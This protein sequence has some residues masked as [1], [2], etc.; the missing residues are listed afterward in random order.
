MQVVHARCCGLDVHKKTVVACTLLTSSDGSVEKHTRTFSPMT[1]D[2]LALADWLDTL[3]VS[4]VAMESTGVFWRPV[5]NLLEEGRSVM[6]VNAQHMRAVPGHKTDVKDS[7][8]L[9]DLLRHG[10][11]KASF[12]PPQPIRQLRELTRY[13]K[14]LVQERAQEVNRLQKVLE[15]ANVKL[16]AVATDILGKSG[17]SI[18]AALL[19][20]ERDQQVLAELARGRMRSKRA[21]LQDALTGRLQP[22]H[23]VL[24]ERMLEHVDF[25][26]ASLAQLQQAI[27][28]C[29]A[30]FEE[31][32]ELVQTI[33][34]VQAKAASTIVAEIG[35]DMTRFP[36]AKHLASWAGV[37][38]GN[39]ESGGKRLSGKTTNGNTYL[40]AVLT[41]V[42]WVVSRM[43]DNYLA[44]QYH[45]LARRL[46]K[47]KAAVAV[48][49]SI[50]V[51]VYHILRTHKP[52]TELG[53]HY[54]DQLDA[55]RVQQH[56]VHR[57]EQLGYTVTLSP[58]GPVDSVQL[59][60]GFS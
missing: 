43:K 31:A 19:E 51:M 57:L 23:L 55:E 9:A 2:L 39:K 1:K 52:Y 35:V 7:E 3:E 36:S 25:I 15:L 4:Q 16:S 47:K 53:A 41:E 14:T 8:W 11:L 20:G 34:G 46:G 10:L 21:Q 56:H 45:R 33:P 32:L 49:H 42:V 5:F 44:A 59:G 18:L 58:T 22:H 37:C 28:T 30:P 50:L 40:R 48:A 26:D 29:L 60:R 38:P 6:V 13:R 54:F 24:L 12:I 27:D 17:R